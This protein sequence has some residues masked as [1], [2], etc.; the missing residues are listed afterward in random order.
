MVSE[1]L[2]GGARSDDGRKATM[3]VAKIAKKMEGVESRFVG[4]PGRKAPWVDIVSS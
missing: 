4:V 3:H 1:D 2:G